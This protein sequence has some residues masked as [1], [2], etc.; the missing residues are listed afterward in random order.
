MIIQGEKDLMGQ[1]Y[2]A[3]KVFKES[4]SKDI[5]LWYYQ[6]A[7]AAILMEEEYPEIEKRMIEW[8]LK[9]A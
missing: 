6:K 1:A 8:I 4:K 3:V 7:W 5:E 2:H 9:R